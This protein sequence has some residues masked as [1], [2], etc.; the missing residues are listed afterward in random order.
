VDWTTSAQD[1]AFRV[2]SS[3]QNS[4][5]PRR[6]RG[7]QA[8]SVRRLHSCLFLRSA[9]WLA[10]RSCERSERLAKAGGESGSPATRFREAQ[11]LQRFRD[12]LSQ[13]Q[14]FSLF[15][16]SPAFA[17]VCRRLPIFPAQWNSKWNSL[18]PSLL[19]RCRIKGAWGLVSVA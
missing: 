1:L 15:Q 14:R 12:H 18:A 6:R 8:T 10:S 3:R 5:A 11:C 2:G 9:R 7:R 17:S 13:A 16:T 19:D 4:R